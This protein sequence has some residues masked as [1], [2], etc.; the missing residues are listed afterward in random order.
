[1]GWDEHLE[2]LARRRERAAQM[3]GSERVERQHA[4][5]KLTVRERIALLLDGDSFGEIVAVLNEVPVVAAA[6]GSVAGLGA[7]KVTAAHF[8]VMVRGT[9]HVFVAGPPLV[10]Y[11][12]GETVTKEELGGSQIH[13]RNGVVDN[14]AASED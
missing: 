8:S 11:A 4:A 10:P 1:M 14:E 5:G 7:A 6:L 9:S 3:G 2:E 12:T 13:T